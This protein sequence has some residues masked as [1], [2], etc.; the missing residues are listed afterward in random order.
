VIGDNALKRAGLRCQRQNPDNENNN[1][2]S[3]EV[4]VHATLLK[5][6]GF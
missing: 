5:V 3:E 1:D 2:Q 4:P 6:F